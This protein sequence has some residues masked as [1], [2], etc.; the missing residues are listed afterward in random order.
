MNITICDRSITRR[1]T[2]VS[3]KRSYTPSLSVV[4]PTVFSTP[5]DSTA[6]NRERA[7]RCPMS[8]RY[9][10]H[11]AHLH[12]GSES[13]ATGSSK[14]HFRRDR[15][16]ESTCKFLAVVTFRYSALYPCNAVVHS[17]PPDRVN[18]EYFN[19]ESI[20]KRNE[21]DIPSVRLLFPSL[22]LLCAPTTL[23]H[24]MAQYESTW[25]LWFPSV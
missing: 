24:P 2:R 25:D 22:S 19:T 20:S 6:M 7:R 4:T 3:Y 1:R 18:R 17:R 15:R 9:E 12:T 16:R 23:F 5:F 21:A 11:G 13:P 8:A 14:Q 10:R